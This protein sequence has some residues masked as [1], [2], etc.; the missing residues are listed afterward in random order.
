MYKLTNTTSILR[1][2]DNASI[3]NDKANTDYANYLAWLREGN[4]PQPAETIIQNIDIIV[5]P[6]QFRKAINQLG[7]RPAIEGLVQNTA[8]QE[9][10]DGWEYATEF[11]RSDEL[12]IGMAYLLNLSDEDLTSI[13]RLA[14][15]K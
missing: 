7:L 2:S 14:S 4:T 3:P 5:S 11:R 6:W 12:V 8:N 9:I 1:L 15:E 13:F 10:K